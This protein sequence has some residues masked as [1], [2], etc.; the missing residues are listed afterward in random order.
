MKKL[1]KI[2]LVS[3]LV[4]L[5]FLTVSALLVFYA[6][7]L[8]EFAHKN[9]KTTSYMKYFLEKERAKNQ[10]ARISYH[11][12]NLNQIS[13]LMINAVLIAEDDRFYKHSGLDWIEIRTVLEKAA[14]K[15][16]FSR[17]AS[18][19]TQQLVKNLY[20]TPERSFWRKY[21][22]FI[23]TF[24]AEMFL[25]KNR[26]LELYLNVA[27][28]GKLIFGA[29][30]ASRY[31]FNKSSSAL[32]AEEAIRLA[33]ILPNPSK[34]KVFNEKSRLIYRRRLL[35][36]GALRTRNLISREEY[37]KLLEIFKAEYHK[38]S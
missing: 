5:L 21:K 11:Y 25:K 8:K 19:I 34:Y 9:P 37:Q 10:R 33:A 20:L 30:A 23:L 35:I 15:M 22:E 29:E 4:L 18:T 2:A 31:Y 16:S 12:V 13:R 26:I 32:N 6:Y 7:D 24:K 28:F 3:A 38:V 14:Q 27:Q 1:F 36:T 17:G